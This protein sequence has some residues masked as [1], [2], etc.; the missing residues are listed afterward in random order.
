MILLDTNAWIR[1]LHPELGQSM[2]PALRNWL[3]ET[4]LP[5]AVSVISCLEVSQLVK[6]GDLQLPLPLPDWF[7]EALDVSGVSYL[8]L[9]PAIAHASTLLPNIHK[10]P[11]DRLII[12]T[13]QAY[14]AWL[15]TR[16]EVIPQYPGVRVVWDN[17][18]QLKGN[19]EP[20]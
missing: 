10:D 17:T 3:D 6:K 15:V 5:I 20:A 12:A 14:D 19:G 7:H 8:P 2:P 13:A 11:A 18:P 16:D 4:P 9:T 1:W